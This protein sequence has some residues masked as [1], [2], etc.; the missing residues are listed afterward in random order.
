[1]PYVIGLLLGLFIGYQLGWVGA[2]K[3]VARECESLGGFFVGE[4]VFE[5]RPVERKGEGSRP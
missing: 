1:M 5:C 4:Q 3:M 2:H